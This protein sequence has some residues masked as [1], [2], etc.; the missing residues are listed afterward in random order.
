MHVVA[1]GVGLVAGFPSGLAVDDDL[2]VVTEG[3]YD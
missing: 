1:A 3:A 2:S